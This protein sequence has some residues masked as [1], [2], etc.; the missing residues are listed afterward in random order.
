MSNVQ[1]VPLP[2]QNLVCLEML[3][4]RAMTNWLRTDASAAATLIEIE[5]PRLEIVVPTVAHSAPAMGST[6]ARAACRKTYQP[7]RGEKTNLQ[8]LE[9]EKKEHE[10]RNGKSYAYEIVY[11]S[12]GQF[13]CLCRFTHEYIN[14]KKRGKKPSPGATIMLQ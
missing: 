7:A 2:T 11:S 4:R 3:P 14:R 6:S 5:E 1:T 12:C 10:K 9:N 13:A 8:W